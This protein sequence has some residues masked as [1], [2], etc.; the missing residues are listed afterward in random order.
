MVE[1]F[2]AGGGGV[3]CVDIDGGGGYLGFGGGVLFEGSDG[4]GG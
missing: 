2:R 4:G 1:Y 3:L